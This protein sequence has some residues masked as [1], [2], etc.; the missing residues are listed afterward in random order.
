[1][2]NSRGGA[3]VLGASGFVGT[4]L[5]RALA[6]GGAAFVRAVDVAPPR[7]R[8]D[9]V[10]YQTLDVRA[11]LPAACGA[12]ASV[13]YNLAAVHRTPGH[14]DREYY[15]TNVHG[16]LN[17][18]ALAEACDVRTIVFTSSIS[19]YGPSEETLTEASPLRPVSAYGRSKRM[20]E[21]IHDR[22]LERAEDRKLV[23]VRPGIIFG[24]G[25][26]GNYTRLARA[27][28]GGYFFYPGRRDTIKS[29]GYVDELLRAMDFALS[30]PEPRVLFNYAYP[31]LSSIADIVAAFSA[32]DGRRYAPPTV[33]IAPALWGAA[34]F[35]AAGAVGVKTGIHR[36]RIM[37]LVQ[38]TRVA[39]AWLQQSGYQ[40]SSDLAVA[41]KRWSDETGGRFI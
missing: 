8:V 19:V 25:E 26:G 24:P 30:R 5:V 21:E 37:K 38:S 1:V 13:L 39:P 36:E 28:R 31:E 2:N 12:G 34:L 33:P 10:D 18:T 3:V 16:A 6:E 27:L 4:R 35:E 23:I 22:W 15:D 17:A 29:G 20:A 41:L 40:F 9:G 14:P 11:P 7:E 32:V